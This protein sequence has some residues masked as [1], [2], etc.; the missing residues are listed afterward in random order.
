MAG[1]L[2]TGCGGKRPLTANPF[3]LYQ[4]EQTSFT[5]EQQELF[6]QEA[7]DFSIRLFQK[8]VTEGEN[9]MISPMSVLV[10]MSMV[11]KI[12]GVNEAYYDAEVY[13]T[14]EDKAEDEINEWVKK[15]THGMINK[16]QDEVNVKTF[17]YLINNETGLPLFIGTL[18]DMDGEFLQ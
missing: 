5:G 7:T 15:K 14:D 12:I 18:Q 17:V 1:L 3:H 9:F 10:A 16:I 13:Q 4:V 8:S 2:L 6:Q 11:E